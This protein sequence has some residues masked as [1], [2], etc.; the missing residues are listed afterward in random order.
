MEG[1]VGEEV[2]EAMK[3]MKK[4][5]TGGSLQLTDRGFSLIRWGICRRH[6]DQPTAYFYDPQSSYASIPRSFTPSL[7]P[8]LPSLAPGDMGG[9]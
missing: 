7:H 2:E 5:R 6:T 8:P 9:M 3:G 1:C 4:D